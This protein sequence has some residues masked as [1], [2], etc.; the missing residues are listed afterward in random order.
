[1]GFF[2]KPVP[3]EYDTPEYYLLGLYQTP[4]SQYRHTMVLRTKAGILVT[5]SYI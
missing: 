4:Q 1:M 5:P 3:V 2:T